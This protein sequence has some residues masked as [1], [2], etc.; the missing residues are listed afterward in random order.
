MYRVDKL[1]MINF[2]LVIYNIFK[3]VELLYYTTYWIFLLALWTVIVIHSIYY[4]HVLMYKHGIT[5]GSMGSYRYL[6]WF[7]GY[8]YSVQYPLFALRLLAFIG[9]F[10]LWWQTTTAMLLSTTR[11]APS[12]QCSGD[13]IFCRK[14][15]EN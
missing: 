14:F 2:K 9:G 11:R 5:L 13:K 12:T 7:H 15:F 10:A 3:K 8:T 6:I 1:L 4:I